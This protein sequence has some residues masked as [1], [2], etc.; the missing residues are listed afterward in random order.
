MSDTPKIDYVNPEL[1]QPEKELVFGTGN[2]E[3]I[4]EL[5]FSSNTEE[6]QCPC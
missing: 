5:F 1:M 2:S 6:S 3:Y 4:P